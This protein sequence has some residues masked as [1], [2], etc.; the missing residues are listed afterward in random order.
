MLAEPNALLN[1]PPWGFVKLLV[2]QGMNWSLAPG[3]AIRPSAL[4]S[5]PVKL[6]TSYLTD[7]KPP[8]HPSRCLNN[9]HPKRNAA[10]ATQRSTAKGGWLDAGSA[11]RILAHHLG[12]LVAWSAN[13]SPAEKKLA[14][15][16]FHSLMENFDFVEHRWVITIPEVVVPV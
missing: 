3:D 16:D 11:M 13:A 6:K 7:C 2:N 8:T 5:H 1:H 10:N 14:S 15:A 12:N 9:A 4:P